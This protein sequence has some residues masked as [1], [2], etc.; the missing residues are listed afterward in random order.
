MCIGW[1]YSPCIVEIQWYCI[2]CDIK[3]IFDGDILNIISIP[4]EEL[5]Y[6]FRKFSPVDRMILSRDS[7]E[8]NDYFTITKGQLIDL[9][10]FCIC[11][12]DIND[13]ENE[14]VSYK[15]INQ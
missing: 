2:Q 1:R 13:I 5:R 14:T 7:G 11:D 3:T 9:H 4:L 8:L 6:A 12:K 15:P 10:Y